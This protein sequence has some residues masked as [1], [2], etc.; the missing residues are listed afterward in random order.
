MADE[1]RKGS[2]EEMNNEQKTEKQPTGVINVQ[3]MNEEELFLRLKDSF[4][5]LL[6]PAHL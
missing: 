5:S 4:D 6:I 1:C 3:M 2:A